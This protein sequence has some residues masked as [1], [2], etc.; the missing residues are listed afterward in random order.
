MLHTTLEYENWNPPRKSVWEDPEVV[1]ET[2]KWA[3][4]RQVVE[5]SRKYGRIAHSVNPC[6]EDTHD[7]WWANVRD[8]IEGKIAVKDAL[9]RAG[10][11]MDTLVSKMLSKA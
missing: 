2:K 11:T 4:Y 6:L 9:A 3:N 7:A 8:A 1:A 10:L 5:E